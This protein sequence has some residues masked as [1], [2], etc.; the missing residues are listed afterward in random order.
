[1]LTLCVS[2]PPCAEGLRTLRIRV[3][4]CVVYVC[5]CECD[6]YVYVLYCF[7]I[8]SGRSDKATT[9]KRQSTQTRRLQVCM[10]GVRVYDCLNIY[11][12]IYIYIYIRNM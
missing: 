7:G 10:C 1:M 4:R 5:A 12:Y 6:M 2:A 11:I 9:C 8:F 3:C